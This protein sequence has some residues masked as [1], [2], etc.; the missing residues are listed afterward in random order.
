MYINVAHAFKRPV[1]TMVVCRNIPCFI[2]SE[3]TVSNVIYM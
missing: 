3:V 2:G 1:Q